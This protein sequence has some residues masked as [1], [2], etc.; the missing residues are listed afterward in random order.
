MLDPVDEGDGFRSRLAC[1]STLG[2]MDGRHIEPR[3][4]LV[5]VVL[6]AVVLELTF[7]LSLQSELL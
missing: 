5:L 4:A 6:V 3:L 7:E 2:V 1:G